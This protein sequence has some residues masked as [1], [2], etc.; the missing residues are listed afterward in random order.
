[1]IL[2]ESKPPGRGKP[3]WMRQAIAITFVRDAHP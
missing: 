2:A 3:V 1:M